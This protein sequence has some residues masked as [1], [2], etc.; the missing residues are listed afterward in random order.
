MAPETDPGLPITETEASSSLE[1]VIPLDRVEAGHCGL[2]HEVRAGETEIEQLQAMG[3]CAGRKVMLVKAGD[4]MI[5]KVLGSR[6]GVSARLA[7]QVMV[8][9]CGGDMFGE[10]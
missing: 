7:S 3:V 4:P 9:R 5:L 1:D 8:V 2:V 10:S 6:I